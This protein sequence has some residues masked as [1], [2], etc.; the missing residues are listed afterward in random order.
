MR[1]FKI[2][3]LSFIVV[4]TVACSDE[5]TNVEKYYMGTWVISSTNP[6]I[7]STVNVFVSAEGNFNY[8]MNYGGGELDVT[9]IVKENGDVRADVTLDELL[10]GISR[11]KFS[12]EATGSGE[13]TI[14]NQT[15]Q[16]TAKKK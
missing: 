6:E 15:F 10:L 2:M 3:V 16:W 8:L 1:L 5:E 14:V 11:G 4:S 9:G 7:D 12:P 13:Y